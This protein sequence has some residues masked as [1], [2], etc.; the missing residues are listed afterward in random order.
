MPKK[1]RVGVINSHRF[2]AFAGT[3]D[4][5]ISSFTVGSDTVDFWSIFDSAFATPSRYMQEIFLRLGHLE[6][7]GNQTAKLVFNPLFDANRLIITTVLAIFEA[8]ASVPSMAIIADQD[9]LPAA[10]LFPAW[11]TAGDSRF[12]TLLSAVDA[13]TDAELCRLLFFCDVELIDVRHLFLKRLPHN[14][15]LYEPNKHIY[16]WIAERAK[17]MARP[18]VEL[19]PS[20]AIRRRDAIPFT[21]FMPHHAGDVLFF[22]IAWNSV[23]T[24]IKRLAVNKIYCHIAADVAP[25][26]ALFSIE[27]TPANRSDELRHGKVVQDNDYF[28]ANC[29]DLPEDCFYSY[30]RPSRDYNVTRLHLIDHFAFA[31]GRHCFSNEDLPSR[32]C[33]VKLFRPDIP[34]EPLRILLH[35]GAGWPLKVYPRNSQ[36]RL[37][38]LLYSKGYQITVLSDSIYD[39]PKCHVTTFQDY[40]SFKE[41]VK[42]HHVL[43]GMDSFPS[44]YAAHVLGLPVVCLFAS[45]RP[46]NSNAPQSVYYRYMEQGLGC[47]P[48]YGIVTCPLHGGVDCTNFVS[49]ESIALAIREMLDDIEGPLPSPAPR[50]T[51]DYEAPSTL[52]E[53]SRTPRRINLQYPALRSLICLTTFKLMSPLGFVSQIHGEFMTSLRRDGWLKTYL[54][55]LRFMNRT[56]RHRFTR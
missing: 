20:E 28:L 49:P 16:Q 47:R 30:C 32:A 38:D 12:L 54:R 40:S 27:K 2:S 18:L 52:P 13:G 15:F 36:E 19:P 53:D 17:A 44:H 37:I 6:T 1:I 21:A 29:N 25:E 56:L 39:H 5:E 55:A 33:A 9:G 45:T 50:A 34:A 8:R 26:L 31:L 48:C 46:E 51:R 10:Y 23:K 14:S 7:K 11:L 35:L 3:Y 41:L 42:S 22:A 43:V 4:W 24:P